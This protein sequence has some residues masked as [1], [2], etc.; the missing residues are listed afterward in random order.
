MRDRW[1]KLLEQI[2]FLGVSVRKSSDRL[3]TV[4]NYFQGPV[5]FRNHQRQAETL[6]SQFH[7]YSKQQKQRIQIVAEYSHRFGLNTNC[8]ICKKLT[9]PGE[10]A[11]YLNRE[12]VNRSS[13][14]NTC[15]YRT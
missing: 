15:R 1:L 14:C 8:A 3:T 9:W 13:R 6:I 12:N 5:S 7:I 4:M 2:H 11:N 10:D